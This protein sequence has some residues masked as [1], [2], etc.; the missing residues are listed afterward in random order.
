MT[1]S[2]TP[3]PTMR[4]VVDGLYLVL[5]GSQGSNSRFHITRD[6]ITELA[7]LPRLVVVDEAQ[8]LSSD[9]IETLRHLHD[10][11]NTPSS[12][13]CTSAGTAA[14]RSCRASR[15]WPRGSGGAWP[16]HRWSAR[17]SRR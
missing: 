13:C 11:D 3:R 14:G 15:C 10:D 6:L 7:R 1:V 12:G 8:R 4:Q 16:W 2:F 17:S 9:G 5:T